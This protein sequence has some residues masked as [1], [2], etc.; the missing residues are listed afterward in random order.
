MK[1]NEVETYILE[2]PCCNDNCKFMQFVLWKLHCEQSLQMLFPGMIKEILHIAKI[3]QYY[4]IA[5]LP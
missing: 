4:M 2:L 5:I 1:V 3:Q